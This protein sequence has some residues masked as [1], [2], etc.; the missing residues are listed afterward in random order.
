MKFTVTVLAVAALAT[1][2]LAETWHPFS[3]SA[4]NAFMADVDSIAVNGD[5]TAV[6]VATAPLRGEAGDLSHTIET[7]EFQCAA[8]QWR[9]AGVVEY[10]P[11]GAEAG[12]FPEEGAQWETARANTMPM[13]LKQIAC[14]GR[15][16]Q[17]PVWPTV[18]AFFEAG[19]PQA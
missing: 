8:D 13:F 2:A 4:N 7:Y 19:R 14:D 18:R 6:R 17:P 3:R 15:R 12:R 10:G 11:D 5:I 9:T 1:P 16:A